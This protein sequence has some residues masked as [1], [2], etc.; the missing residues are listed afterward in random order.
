MAG[1]GQITIVGRVGADPEL[2]TVGQNGAVVAN[3]SVATTSR[4][5]DKAT[6]QWQDGDT[7]WYECSAWRDQAENI[8]ATLRKGSQVLLTGRVKTRKYTKGD[9][10]TGLALEVQIENIGTL[11]P[12]WKPKGTGQ[13][14]GTAS[15]SYGNYGSGGTTSYGADQATWATQ[16][17]DD[18]TPF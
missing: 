6:Q 5:K 4:V 3:F 13:W 1:E 2:T 7:T 10:S 16:Q 17:A 15:T 11:I 12:T 8:A 18:E 14:G 9:G